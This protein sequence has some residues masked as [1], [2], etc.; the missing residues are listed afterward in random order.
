MTSEFKINLKNP[1]VEDEQKVREI[2]QTSN[3]PATE[4]AIESEAAAATNSL[5]VDH[6]PTK[7]ELK[8]LVD[9][10]NKEKA[11]TNLEASVEKE[12]LN[13]RVMFVGED[14]NERAALDYFVTE[15]SVRVDTSRASAPLMSKNM[16]V[17]IPEGNVAPSEDQIKRIQEMIMRSTRMYQESPRGI[18][19]NNPVRA[20]KNPDGLS[21]RQLKKQ[22]RNDKS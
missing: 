7:E 1:T 10:V 13:P 2:M 11:E 14:R 4:N 20:L 12:S 5:L 8:N 16:Q 22:R 6:K 21:R 3:V 19:I 18:S 9:F 17:E 15:P